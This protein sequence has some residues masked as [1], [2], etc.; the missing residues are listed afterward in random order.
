L[1]ENETIIMSL[2]REVDCAVAQTRSDGCHMPKA[3]SPAFYLFT[4][5]MYHATGKDLVAFV[6]LLSKL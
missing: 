5:E 4:Y 6:I 1:G 2:S 3:D